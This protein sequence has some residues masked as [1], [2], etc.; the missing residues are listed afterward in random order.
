MTVYDS[1]PKGETA[2]AG[3]SSGS[4]A[5]PPHHCS[6]E[7]RRSSSSFTR[8]PSV[9]G[10]TGYRARGSRDSLSSGPQSHGTQLSPSSSPSGM[11]P[12]FFASLKNVQTAQKTMKPF[13]RS[14]NLIVS[15]FRPTSQR[16]STLRRLQPS[17]ARSSSGSRTRPGA[18]TDVTKTP[19]NPK[20]RH[21]DNIPPWRCEVSARLP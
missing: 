6:L 21:N 5:A 13:Q 15:Q 4:D 2:R 12:G 1:G 17:K 18:P 7:A 16:E 14:S 19:E 3:P 11:W 8:R 10:K 9:L 20:P